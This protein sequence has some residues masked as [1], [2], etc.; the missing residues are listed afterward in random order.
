[1]LAWH[2]WVP[3]VGHKMLVWHTEGRL[4]TADVQA[5]HLLSGVAATIQFDLI[6]ED[7]APLKPTSRRGLVRGNRVHNRFLHLV[8]RTGIVGTGGDEAGRWR[9]AVCYGG[10]RFGGGRKLVDDNGKVEKLEKISKAVHVEK[11]VEEA[12]VEKVAKNDEEKCE[13]QVMHPIRIPT[14]AAITHVLRNKQEFPLVRGVECILV[15][16]FRF[17]LYI[18]RFIKDDEVD[19]KEIAAHLES[20]FLRCF[21]KVDMEVAGVHAGDWH[22]ANAEEH[23]TEPVASDALGSTAVVAVICSTHI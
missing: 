4:L 14:A 11:A 23:I 9:D 21:R 2:Q 6:V 13:K 18:V 7:E 10:W 5:L 8:T 19:V 1:M 12:K 20:A 3:F 22:N 16:N 15:I 17:I